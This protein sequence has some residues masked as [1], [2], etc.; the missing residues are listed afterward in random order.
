MGNR[1]SLSKKI[2]FEVFKR[3]SFKCQYC[4]KSAPNVILEVDH[5]NPV[6]KGG[7]NDLL[8]LITSCYDCNRG[9][10][11]RQIDDNSVILKQ[12]QQLELLQERREQIDLMFNWRKELDNLSSDIHEMIVDYIEDKIEP[13]TL[14]ESGSK[15]I[16]KLAK[17]YNLADI[18]EAVDLSEEKYLLYDNKGILLDSSVQ[19]FIN[20]ITGILVNQ[21]RPPVENKCSYIKGICRNRFNYWN[22]QQGSII[23]NKY[24]KALRE[25]GWSDERILEDLDQKVI[26]KTTEVKNWTE[27]RQLIEKWTEDIKGWESNNTLKSSHP[28]NTKDLDECVNCLIQTR[29][30][31]IP[32]LNHIGSGFPYY[33]PE[34]LPLCLDIWLTSY[35]KDLGEFCSKENKYTDKKPFYVE[36]FHGSIITSLFYNPDNDKF[37][38]YL[39]VAF[40]SILFELI[41]II[42]KYTFQ[43]LEPQNITYINNRYCILLHGM[44]FDEFVNPD[45]W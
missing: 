41:D 45:S 31:L 5:I 11:D 2:R 6:S 39:E 25:Y 10:S 40:I 29:K 23:L 15:K 12:R 36:A 4:G 1:N 38:H 7:D 33:D 35:L 26:P 14:S 28:I 3:D 9:K 34:R 32:V 19:E 13:Y 27:W 30:H 20:K 21:N 24:V 22:P 8:N 16:K 17:K 44:S 43:N 37:I 42:E 18:L